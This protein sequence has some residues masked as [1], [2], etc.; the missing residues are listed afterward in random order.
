MH[1]EGGMSSKNVLIS[2]FSSFGP[3]LHDD[4]LEG[5]GGGGGENGYQ[6][7]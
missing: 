6:L 7:S 3:M 5:A 4:F 1:S 2:D